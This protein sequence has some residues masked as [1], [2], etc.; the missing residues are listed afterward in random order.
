MLGSAIGCSLGVILILMVN[1]IKAGVFLI[2]FL[3]IKQIEDNFI[4]PK[5]VGESVGLPAIW[6]LVAIT[7]GGKISGV[8]GMIIFIP[9]FS[10]AYVLLRKEVYIRL[11]GKD[12]EIK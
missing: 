4:Y 2:V 6:V 7:L 9:M 11:K 10:V 3:L 1:P 8:A 5:V 12:L